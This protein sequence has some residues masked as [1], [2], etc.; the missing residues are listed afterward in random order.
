M[1]QTRFV[2]VF[3]LLF[4]V[5]W[6]HGQP[7][8]TLLVGYYHSPP[9]VIENAEG[10]LTGVS[11]WLW[12]E[13][14]KDLDYAYIL[15][16]YDSDRPLHDLLTDLE[17]GKIDMAINPLTITSS[18]D[19]FVDFSYPYYVADLTIAKSSTSKSGAWVSVIKEFFNQR[20]LI[21]IAT[22]ACLVLLFGF[23]LW[24]VERKNQHFEPGI[25]GVLSSFWWSAVTMTTVGYG[26]KVPI[27]NLGRF[28]AFIWM[29]C[30]II[31]IAIFTASITS[32]LTIHRLTDSNLSLDTFK[33]ARVGTV[34]SSASQEFLKHNFFRDIQ[35]YPELRHG[36]LAL[37]NG[38]TDYFVYDE[39]WLV[40]LLDNDPEL[41]SLELL[42][43]QFHRELYAFP[44]KENISRSFE[45]QLSS[46]LIRL[47][48]TKDWEMVLSEYNLS[49]D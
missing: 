47:M 38:E 36:L 21:L 32:S 18:R 40:Y 6:S 41:S 10:K 45:K 1:N 43:I 3:L 19:Q 27:S 39:P 46:N 25:Q 12:E 31:I 37:K 24:L 48:E 44:M 26:D 23:L 7:K 5:F 14:N 49:I 9:F 2:L 34:D 42:P 20:V 13:I 11:V 29:L 15:K 8:D 4:S 30:S 33:Q 16:S 22:L 35:I 17:M 28:I